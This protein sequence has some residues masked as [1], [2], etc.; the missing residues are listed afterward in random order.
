M[1][2]RL[3][4]KIR[5]GKSKGILE[6]KLA[7]EMVRDVRLLAY[8]ATMSNRLSVKGQDFLSIIS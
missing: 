2:V 5:M 7:E 3:A 6:L 1:T 4:E 8:V